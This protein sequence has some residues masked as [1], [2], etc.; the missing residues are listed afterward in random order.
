[1]F[2]GEIK[3]YKEH[4]EHERDLAAQREAIQRE[5]EAFARA[6]TE[7][8]DSNNGLNNYHELPMDKITEEPNS[9]VYSVQSSAEKKYPHSHRVSP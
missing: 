2:E 9:E 8:R 1:M 5:Y 4:R 7:E 3:T 6:Q